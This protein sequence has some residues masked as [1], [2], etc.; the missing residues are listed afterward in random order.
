MT[1][2]ILDEKLG[3]QRS[4]RLYW[5]LQQA[6]K[7]VPAQE[8]KKLGKSLLPIYGRLVGRR[9]KS[10]ARFGGKVL[11]QGAKWAVRGWQAANRGSLPDFGRELLSEV[12]GGLEQR[13]RAMR[14][15]AKNWLNF[16]KN[17]P[18]E[19]A[20]QMVLAMIGFYLGS[21]GMDGDGGIPDLDLQAGIGYHRSIATHS[22]FMAAFIQLLTIAGGDV[23]N[24]I[25]HHLPEPHD[26]IWEQVKARMDILLP[27]FAGATCLGVA[28]HLGV[29]SLIDTGKAYAD[30][31][32]SASMETHQWLMGSQA[33]AEVLYQSGKKKGEGK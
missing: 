26:G 30:L 17:N 10:L 19:A 21:G 29:D 15:V 24:K 11:R 16:F 3:K 22:V 14:S 9:V 32:F 27:A 13:W 6:V 20:P 8:W 31:P 2:I 12:K 33:A 1:T 28:Y 7:A 5:E 18:R 4:E 23:F 25:Y